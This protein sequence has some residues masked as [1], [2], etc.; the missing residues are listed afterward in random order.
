MK[1][2]CHW[3]SVETHTEYATWETECGQLFEYSMLESSPQKDWF[4]YCPYCGR[5]LVVR[6]N[7]GFTD[8]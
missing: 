4:A 8:E 5:H 7:E 6:I 2:N 3:Q 1:I